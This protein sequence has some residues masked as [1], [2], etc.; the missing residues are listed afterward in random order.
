[1]IC[2]R[3]SVSILS[4]HAKNP[5]NPSSSP[6]LFLTSNLTGVTIAS[7]GSGNRWC[8][9]MKFLMSVM[10]AKEEC[11]P[12]FRMIAAIVVILQRPG[13]RNGVGEGKVYRHDK[14]EKRKRDIQ[15]RLAITDLVQ[16]YRLQKLTRSPN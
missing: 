7:G 13:V 8:I 16:K 9:E 14:N 11:W 2:H 1:M 3:V 4:T 6:S 15:A 12:R 10:S 5:F